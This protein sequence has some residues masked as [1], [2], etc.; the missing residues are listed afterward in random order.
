MNPNKTYIKSCY[1]KIYTDA[2]NGNSASNSIIHNSV[3][4]K[5][6]LTLQFANVTQF[7]CWISKKHFCRQVQTQCLLLK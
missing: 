7:S 6:I 5:I 2:W 3:T 1:C 4:Y